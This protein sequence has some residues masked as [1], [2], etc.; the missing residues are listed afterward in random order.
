VTLALDGSALRVEVVDDGGGI[1]PDARR[2]VGL[3]AMGERASELGGTCAVSSPAAG[4]TAV[5]A[6]L[7]VRSEA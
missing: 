1:P 2:G 5:V 4:G 3:A 7:P 6:L